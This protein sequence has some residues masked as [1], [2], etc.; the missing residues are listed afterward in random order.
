MD[1]AGCEDGEIGLCFWL[2]QDVNFDR[3]PSAAEKVAARDNYVIGNNDGG[4]GGNRG[5]GK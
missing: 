1:F 5:G 3:T 4:V 2:I